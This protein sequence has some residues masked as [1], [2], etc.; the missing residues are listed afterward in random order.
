MSEKSGKSKRGRASYHHENL[1]QALIDEALLYLK[2]G[3]AEDL[4]LRDLSRRLK[5]SH[6]APYRHFATKEDLLAEI[7][8]QGFR[9]LTASFRRI[10]FL[11]EKPFEEVFK[12]HG[13]A[14]I[15]FIMTNPDQARLMFSGLLC[16]PSRHAESH[17]AGQEA[18]SRL[19]QLI[20]F[21]QQKEKISRNESPVN[22][23]LMI[24]AAVHG[25]A[26][27]MIENQ[28]SMIENVQPFKLESYVR[29]MSETLLRGM[30]SSER[31]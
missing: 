24:W 23:G 17:K 9:A 3:R 21:G 16:D 30:R 7:V 12:E 8:T 28:F 14:Y 2:K 4:S 6:A 5:V 29:M 26:M 31:G 1:R 25:S 18:F 22:L 10:E 20:Q 15:E 13:F 11:S 27:L 19:I